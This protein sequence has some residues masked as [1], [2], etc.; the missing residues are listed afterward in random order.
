MKKAEPPKKA[1]TAK[2]TAKA[3]ADASKKRFGIKGKTPPPAPRQARVRP[4]LS[5]TVLGDPNPDRPLFED[6]IL[7]QLNSA[8][9][10]PAPA[11]APVETAIDLDWPKQEAPK[12]TAERPD[13]EV[14]WPAYV[15]GGAHDDV[16]AAP[17]EDFLDLSWPPAATAD[18]PKAQ[19][20]APAR[21]TRAAAKAA[22]AKPATAKQ[23]PAKPA[24][25]KAAAK[26]PVAPVPADAPVDL[27]WPPADTAPAE[28]AAVSPP[29]P[30]LAIDLDLSAPPPIPADATEDVT[31]PAALELPIA[32]R[33]TADPV[34]SEKPS[35]AIEL[36]LSPTP[37]QVDVP[38]API[39]I[40]AS[41]PDLPAALRLGPT[42]IDIPMDL[43]PTPPVPTLWTPE[44]RERTAVTTSAETQT[45][46][47]PVESA[48]KIEVPSAPAAEPTP[49]EVTTDPNL[50]P[51]A[52]NASSPTEVA[53]PEVTLP[54]AEA[55]PE[56]APLAPALT[57]AAVTQP[58]PK[59][60]HAR[61]PAPVEVP[62]AVSVP[63]PV[64]AAP[65]EAPVA[66]VEPAQD[67]AP[68]P[69][70]KKAPAP[71]VAPKV[72]TPKAEA[73]VEAPKAEALVEIP[74]PVVEAEVTEVAAPVAEV[75]VPAPAP[76]PAAT[77]APAP[78]AARKSRRASAPAPASA[79][80]DVTPPPAPIQVPAAVE[81]AA[82][83]GQVAAPG[84]PTPSELTKA[85]NAK[86]S[87]SYSAS[88]IGRS[89]NADTSRSDDF[90]PYKPI[91]ERNI[92]SLEDQIADAEE[93]VW[94]E[95]AAAL[96][97]RSA[98]ET[99]DRKVD[100]LEVRLKEAEKE[101]RKVEA[102]TRDE[103]GDLRHARKLEIT[104][105][106]RRALGDDELALHFD[107]RVGHG[108]FVFSR[109]DDDGARPGMIR[110]NRS[111]QEHE[112]THAH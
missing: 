84:W 25:R 14:D 56:A 29:P 4:R 26:P 93:L 109:K 36:D 72:E 33:R 38:P 20:K 51:A 12:A 6:P 7:T 1:G 110:G 88:R 57:K 8:D 97:D 24:A 15:E 87:A 21:P 40:A 58:A 30:V 65:A 11:S 80:V 47:S 23:T 13:F 103:D 95:R 42:S 79:I 43:S 63:A 34:E 32:P 105:E 3:P 102:R 48:P 82:D 104:E 31:A 10:G 66:Q 28:P 112:A 49:H 75:E 59:P 96:W 27:S 54:V 85:G 45:A 71:R 74:A 83:A 76:V 106:I 94:I 61:Q 19:A 68:T 22:P 41:I 44:P 16:A 77:P 64:Q 107:I 81:T 52:V 39:D 78:P 92:E 5:V 98:T 111:A 67:V 69:R 73:P 100:W 99:E 89:R 108:R 18:A 62:A 91:H 60:K 37:P 46:P 70:A 55:T 90:R 17:G 2:T 35:F 9:A 50:A 53:W 101:L 86:K